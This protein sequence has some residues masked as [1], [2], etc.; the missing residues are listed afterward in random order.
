MKLRQAQTWKCGEEYFRIVKLE[1]LEVAY[2]SFKSLDSSAGQHQV[3]SKKNFCRMLKGATLVANK[4][5]SVP[6]CVS[7][8]NA[9][10]DSPL[11]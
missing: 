4:P 2:K 1:R 11:I 3:T 9:V 10:K 7:A 6:P 8:A 5:A